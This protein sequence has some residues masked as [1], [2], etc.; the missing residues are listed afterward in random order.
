MNLNS[1]VFENDQIT[2]SRNIKNFLQSKFDCFQNFQQIF[3]IKIIIQQTFAISEKITNFNE[4]DRNKFLKLKLKT[5]NKYSTQKINID[6]K[7][8]NVESSE[9]LLNTKNSYS[10]K[11]EKYYVK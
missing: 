4:F 10:K 5:T 6:I 7:N 8:K 3:E 1:K 2:S 11:N 9:K